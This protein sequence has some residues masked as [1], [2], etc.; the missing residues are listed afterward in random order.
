[1]NVTTRRRNDELR[2]FV[3]RALP[4]AVVLLVAGSAQADDDRDMD[5]EIDF[6]INAVAESSCTFIRNGKEHDAAA[7]S[8]HLQMKRKRGKKYYEST[9]QFIAR[10]ASKSSWTGDQ[11]LIRCGTGVTLA[12]N[13]WFGEKLKT[14]RDGGN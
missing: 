2:Q 10:I 1:M 11:Y 12:A 4:V 14:Y 9:E 13:E 3:L 8:E 6:L 7:A 5:A